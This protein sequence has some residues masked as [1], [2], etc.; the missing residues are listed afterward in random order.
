MF[1]KLVNTN[2]APMATPY[3]NRYYRMSLALAEPFLLLGGNRLVLSHS[4]FFTKFKEH[5]TNAS[6]RASKHRL[7]WVSPQKVLENG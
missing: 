7:A 1:S 3:G 5:L 6:L 2:I 4:M